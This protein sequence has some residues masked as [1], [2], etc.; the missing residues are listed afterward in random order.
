MSYNGSGIMKIIKIHACQS[1]FIRYP[2]L[3]GNYGFFM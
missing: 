1:D 3:Q 2:F